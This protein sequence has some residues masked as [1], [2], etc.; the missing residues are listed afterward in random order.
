LVCHRGDAEVK[1]GRH[2]W[3]PV[4]RKIDVAPEQLAKIKFTV[5]LPGAASPAAAT[6]AAQAPL[7]PA[8]TAATG[9]P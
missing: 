9:L 2:D 6:S 1:T 8:S 3:L 4:L 7:V 5:T